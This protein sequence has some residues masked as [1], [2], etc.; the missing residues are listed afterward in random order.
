MVKAVLIDRENGYTLS[1]YSMD[2]EMTNNIIVFDI[3]E[4]GEAPPRGYKEMI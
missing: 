2:Q 1:Q 4:E 3:R